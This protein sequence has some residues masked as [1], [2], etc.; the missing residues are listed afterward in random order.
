M[1]F[2]CFVYKKGTFFPLKI[3]YFILFEKLNQLLFPQIS[4]YFWYIFRKFNKEN[5]KVVV[6]LIDFSTFETCF[7]FSVLFFYAVK[8]AKKVRKKSSF[9]F[10]SNLVYVWYEFFF[11]FL[12]FSQLFLS[13][14][15]FSDNFVWKRQSHILFN[16]H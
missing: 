12:L 15:Y 4:L 2:F 10:T 9:A 16:E 1:G 7:L 6:C 5:A 13:F 11:L 3:I 8:E 14:F